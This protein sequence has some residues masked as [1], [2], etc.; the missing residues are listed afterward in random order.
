MIYHIMCAQKPHCLTA[1]GA[2]QPN[3]NDMLL[4]GYVKND[5]MERPYL[6]GF[7]AHFHNMK[8]NIAI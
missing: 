3:N 5:S 6:C 1:L 7:A 8:L 2:L 4:A